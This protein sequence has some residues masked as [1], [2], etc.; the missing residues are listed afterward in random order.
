MRKLLLVL[1]LC[2]P[3]LAHDH[4]NPELNDW[5]RSLTNEINGSCCDGS[6]AYSVNDPDWEIVAGNVD[7]P[8][9]VRLDG[10]WYPVFKN[11]VVKQTN[12]MGIARVWPY[13]NT[14]DSGAPVSKW[15]IRCFL[16]GSGA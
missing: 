14:D 2:S 5:L 3:A 6:D 12:K 9:R 13:R 1:L 7:F 10:E 8:Y 16:P 11:N 15:S 4:D